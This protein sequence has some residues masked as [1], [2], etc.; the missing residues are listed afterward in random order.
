MT[1]NDIP[2]TIARALNLIEET[3]SLSEAA[4]MLSVT[5]PAI[6]KGIAQLEKRLGTP[7]MRRG[8]RPLD[9]TEEGKA[10]AQ[11][12]VQADLLRDRALRDL[13]DARSSRTGTVRLGSFGSSASFHILPGALAAFARLYPRTSV[14]VV[15]YPD[16]ELQQALEDGLVDLAVMTV[17]TQENLEVLPIATDKLVALVSADHPLA[18]RKSVSAVDMAQYPFIMTKGGS[19]P[20]VEKWFASAGQEPKI[21][22]TIL[23]VN[24]IVALVEAGLGVSIIAELALPK[25]SLDCQTLQLSPKA[26]RSIG[27]VR[28]ERTARSRAVERFWQFCA[29]IE[30]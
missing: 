8:C 4:R 14:E 17:P 18:D 15:E 27:F 7:V 13:T 12:A 5:Q 16:T 24:S 11:Y 30:R 22:H 21:V 25:P 19:G 9:L 10:L 1:Q 26:P 23:Q 20:L 28:T 6:S 3:G 2:L 29:G